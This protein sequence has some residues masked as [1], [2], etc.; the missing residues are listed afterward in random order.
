MECEEF[1]ARYLGHEKM[2]SEEFF[3]CLEHVRECK[4]CPDHMLSIDLKNQGV[5]LGRYPC[6]HMAKYATF[7]CDTHEDLIECDDT[8]ILYDAQFDEYS[9]NDPRPAATPIKNC[10][11]CGTQLPNKS[12]LWFSE[13]EKLGFDDPF[14]QDIPEK[15]KSDSW[16]TNS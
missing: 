11:W 9:I 14:D 10:P 8:I 7:K 5:D 12:D 6:I 3:E 4:V 16:Y 13:L 2:E 1:R 15:F